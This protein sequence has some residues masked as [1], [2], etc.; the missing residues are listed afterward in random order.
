MF[1]LLLWVDFFVVGARIALIIGGIRWSSVI[2]GDHRWLLETVPVNIVYMKWSS[3]NIRVPMLRGSLMG[4]EMRM[5]CTD[6]MHMCCND[7]IRL[8]C[9]D[10]IRM[11]WLVIDV[12]HIKKLLPLILNFLV[13]WV[14]KEKRYQT[15]NG[16]SK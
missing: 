4:D 2:F 14:Q 7:G 13:I 16:L 6:G 10:G 9:S 12:P 5:C 3:A 1:C 11:C 15:R 8:C